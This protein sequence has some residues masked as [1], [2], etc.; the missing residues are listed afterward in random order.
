M[1][2]FLM[3]FGLCFII[4]FSSPT[5]AQDEESAGFFERMDELSDYMN[6]REERQKKWR[7]EEAKKEAEKQADYDRAF[8]N[9]SSAYD[10]PYAKKEEDKSDPFYQSPTYKKALKEDRREGYSQGKG[11]DLNEWAGDK[12]WTSEQVLRHQLSPSKKKNYYIHEE[13]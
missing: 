5:M 13:D 10:N 11:T 4:S 2:K 8:S 9:P 1:K 6:E 3:L 12:P 7:A